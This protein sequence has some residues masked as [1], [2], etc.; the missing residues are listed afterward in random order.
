MKRYYVLSLIVVVLLALPLLAACG[1]E[2][3]ATTAPAATTAGGA[4]TAA[5]SEVPGTSAGGAASTAGGASTTVGEPLT[6][7]VGGTFALTGAYAEDCA[8]IL[9]GFQDY[10]QW[11]NENHIL[12]PWYPDKTIPANISFEVLWGDDAL[13]PDKTVTIYQDLKSKGLLVER[14]SGT[15][16][17]MAL[18]D[19]LI[20][21]QIG[22]TCQTASPVALQPPGNI[23]LK[24]PLITDSLAAAADWFLES[25]TDTANKP[26]AALLTADSA[27]GRNLDIPEFYAYLKD[28]GY[29]YVGAQFVPQ[30][31]TAPPTTQLA[32][33]KEKK[34]NVTFGAGVNPTT[35]P[36]IKEA[37]RLGMG[38]D[39]AYKITFCFGEA[40]HLQ[41]MV[42]DLGTVADGTV[43]AGDMC[44]WDDPGDGVAFAN[45]LQDTYR[46]NNRNTNI[47]YL[48]GLVEAMTQVEALR[49]ASLEVDPAKLASADV[50][51]KGFW[52]IKDFDTGGICASTLTYGEGHPDGCNMVR[53]QQVQNGKIVDLGSRP[54]EQ[55]I[56]PTAK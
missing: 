16:Q 20:A 41:I 43:V 51:Q 33:L 8:A 40:S 32:W 5:S 52:E 12:A 1:E 56:L 27:L 55:H 19:L 50:L 37:K 6:L 28:I 36:T 42:P 15:P 4:A 11:V 29:D 13:A 54:V 22:A 9:A 35:Q 45:L 14:V 2:T 26:R 44:A 49:L 47:L 24:N 46:P 48:D 30:P 7:Y 25:W 23:F 31:A 39:E 10:I 38:P 34:V 21:D 53:I 3:S 17:T 18:K